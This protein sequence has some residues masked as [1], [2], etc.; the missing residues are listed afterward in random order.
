MQQ[1]K[2]LFERS[3]DGDPDDSAEE[4]ASHAAADARN[5]A[6]A[7]AIAEA[8]E[9]GLREGYARGLQE[10]ADSAAAREAAALEDLAGALD[11]LLTQAEADALARERDAVRLALTAARRIV[12]VLARTTGFAEIEAVV[13]DS[14]RRAMDEP[15]LVLRVSED[16]F[17][18]ARQRVEPLAREAGFAGRVIVLSDPD[19]AAG[20]CR[21]EW[22]DGGAERNAAR[23]WRDI[24]SAVAQTLAGGECEVTANA[25]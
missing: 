16:W 15:R 12:P 11:R 2:F 21:V 19:L 24:E 10:T 9:E 6:L 1:R 25:A 4:P 17:D 3:F 8:R 13:A 18:A 22:A 5:A 7:Q 23:L 14:L 20:D